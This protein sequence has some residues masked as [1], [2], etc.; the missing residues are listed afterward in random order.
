MTITKEIIHDRTEIVGVFK[1]V[2]VRTIAVI[3][4]DG[5]VISTTPKR[6]VLHPS[7]CKRNKDGSYTHIDE[8]ISG[9]SEEVQAICN[10]VWTDDVK[11]A[12]KAKE[13]DDFDEGVYGFLPKDL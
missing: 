6:Y 8:D 5:E 1:A 7:R 13:E 2:Q 12:W 4:E 9:E 3:E 10:A 11:S